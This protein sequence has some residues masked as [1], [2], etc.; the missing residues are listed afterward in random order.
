MAGAKRAGVRGPR[1]PREAPLPLTVHEPR[2]HL[3]AAEAWAHLRTR[4]HLAGQHTFG[5]MR[6]D[7]PMCVRG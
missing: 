2:P 4:E 3:I 7:C 5:N 6:R 1:V